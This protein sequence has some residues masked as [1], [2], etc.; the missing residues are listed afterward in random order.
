MLRP[1]LRPLALLA[2]L[3]TPLAAQQGVVVEE[4]PPDEAPAEPEPTDPA[5]E[6]EPGD[7]APAADDATEADAAVDA[8]EQ[9]P[10]I[11]PDD[12]AGLEAEA[13]RLYAEGDL[14]SALGL[15]ADLGS[16]HPDVAERARLRLT[17]AWLAWQLRDRPG[18]LGHLEAA[19]FEKPDAEFHAE[20]YH[21]DFGVLHQDALRNAVHRRKVLASETINRAVGEIRAGRYRQ[22][23]ELLG[24]ALAIEPSDPD[25]LYNLALVDL[26]EGDDDAALAG[27]ERVLALERG[28]PEG[29]TRALKV[30]ALNNSAVVYFSRGGYEEAE[31]ALAEAVELD[32][33]DAGAWFNLALARQRL[34]R[35]EESYQALRRAHVLEP[36]DVAIARSLAL[37]ELGRDNWVA[38]VALLSEAAEKQPRDADLA[39]H[40]GRA[41][42]GLGNLDGAI[43]S[44]QRSLELDPRDADRAGGTAA[45]LLAETLRSRGEV[46]GWREAAARATELRP[47]DGGAWMLLGLARLAETDLAG[48][49][50][51]L[52][53]ARG[54]APGRADVAHNLGSVYLALRDVV[55]AEEAFAA[56]LELDPTNQ[57]AAAALT[58]LRTRPASA[59][60]SRGRDI[61]AKL[62]ASADSALGV[63]GLRVEGV[64]ASSPAARA[65]LRPG[66]LIVRAA[67]RPTESTDDLRKVLKSTRGSTTLAVL[68]DGKPLELPLSLD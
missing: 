50:R 30:Q 24:R 25:A 59:T 12:Y 21:P 57:E 44:F 33:G 66:D 6:P 9:R 49:R 43:A 46:A 60:G 36:E 63:R 16:R 51:D 47:D 18:A 27:F 67:E 13:M 35:D 40:L 5:A 55:G 22:A 17:A 26:R 11:A 62:V 45:L 68:R 23:R 34:G 54:L 1:I 48:A 39:L 65:G 19:L 20:L 41:Q 32:A 56:A 61:G 29:V 64:E 58:A 37:A 31:A 3:S 14:E 7:E 4:L 15:Y 42:R 2:A 28:D 8:P 10:P 38:A 53:R 52:E